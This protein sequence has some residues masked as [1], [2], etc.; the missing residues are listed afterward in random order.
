MQLSE[1][2]FK[3]WPMHP[4]KNVVVMDGPLDGLIGKTVRMTAANKKDIMIEFTDGT[5]ITVELDN[6]KLYVEVSSDSCKGWMKF[7]PL[8]DTDAL[9]VLDAQYDLITFLCKKCG[10]A[11][12][13]FSLRSTKK[14]MVI[15]P[16]SQCGVENDQPETL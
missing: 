9:E 11:I 12:P 16:C 15:V 8:R 1:S 14:A 10:E 7:V 13:V 2:D 6:G 5:V 4:T 3:Y